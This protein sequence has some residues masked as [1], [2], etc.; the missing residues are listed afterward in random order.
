MRASSLIQLLII[1]MVMGACSSAPK[2]EAPKPAQPESDKPVAG[3]EALP[4]EDKIVRDLRRKADAGN[5]EAQFELGQRLEEGRGVRA[6]REEAGRWY[7]RAGHGGHEDAQKSS[8]RLYERQAVANKAR[9]EDVRPVQDWLRKAAKD[10]D[11]LAQQMLAVKLARGEGMKQDYRESLQW[12]EQL[13]EKG[14]LPAQQNAALMNY[15]GLGTEPNAAS[16]YKWFKAAGEQGDGIAQYIVATLSYYGHG[17]SRNESDARAW[18]RRAAASNDSEARRLAFD[19]L[20]RISESGTPEP[21]AP[22]AA[23]PKKK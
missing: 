16:A 3:E 18:A 7:Q 2:P 9:I 14:S 19:F 6:N 4:G 23:P 13:A 20:G 21:P 17:T 15:Y 11:V 1:A 12:F 10:G 5:R 22:P 8:V